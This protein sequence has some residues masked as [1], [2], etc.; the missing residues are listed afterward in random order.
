[1]L[2]PVVRFLSEREENGIYR[3]D[4]PMSDLLCQPDNSCRARRNGATGIIRMW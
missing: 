4:N 2:K 1:M 3:F